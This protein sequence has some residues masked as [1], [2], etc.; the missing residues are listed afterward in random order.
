MRKSGLKRLTASKVWLADFIFSCHSRKF[1]PVGALSS[2]V[3]SAANSGQQVSDGTRPS[4][5]Q[6]VAGK[7]QG[8][9]ANIARE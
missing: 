8:I 3:T 4:R 5:T 7:K 6:E 1:R 2:N 9:F